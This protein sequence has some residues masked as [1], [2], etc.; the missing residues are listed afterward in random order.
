MYFKT[1]RRRAKI[2]AAL[3][4]SSF[5]LLGLVQPF[6]GT[7][8]ASLTFTKLASFPALGSASIASV[9]QSRDGS[10]I[11]VG[12]TDGYIQISRDSGATWKEQSTTACTTDCSGAPSAIG[13][14]SALAISPDGAHLIAG[15]KT[16]TTGDLWTATISET[17][18][19]WVDHPSAGHEEWKSVVISD[20]GTRMAATGFKTPN[21]HNGVIT[22]SGDSGTVWG[23]RSNPVMISKIIASPDLKIITGI[24]IG[25]Y[26]SLAGQVS[27][28]YGTTWQ[29][30]V[31]YIYYNLR[32]GAGSAAADRLVSFDKDGVFYSSTSSGLFWDDV[33]AISNAATTWTDTSISGDG[34]HIV[35]LDSAK[36]IYLSKDASATWDTTALTGSAGTATSVSIS[37]N[38]SSILALTNSE[39]WR[40]VLN[41]APNLQLDTS[42]QVGVVDH[43]ISPILPLN[44]GGAANY[45]VAPALPAGLTIDPY[46]GTVTGIPSASHAHDTY[47]LTATG[48]ADPSQHSSKTFNLSVITDYVPLSQ[49]VHLYGVIRTNGGT[50]LGNATIQYVPSQM[51]DPITTYSDASGNYD[52]LVTPGPGTIRF[53]SYSPNSVPGVTWGVAATAY[54][55]SS[56]VSDQAI[57][58]YL[59][60]SGQITIPAGMSGLHQDLTIPSFHNLHIHA[61]KHGTPNVPIP[62]ATLGLVGAHD[63]NVSIV[64]GASDCRWN[65]PFVNFSGHLFETDANGDVFVPVLDDST[66][67]KDPSQPILIAQKI[68]TV[69]TGWATFNTTGS[70]ETITATADDKPFRESTDTGAFTTVHLHGTGTVG[71]KIAWCPTLNGTDSSVL[72]FQSNCNLVDATNIAT[73]DGSGNYTLNVTEGSV[74]LKMSTGENSITTSGCIDIPHGTTD[75]VLNLISP[76]LTMKNVTIAVKDEAN[77][78]LTNVSIDGARALTSVKKRS[79]TNYD[80]QL[81]S[82]MI[83]TPTTVACSN[84]IASADSPTFNSCLWNPYAAYDSSSKTS[85]R[86]PVLTSTSALQD[87][88]LGA[89][90]NKYHFII[91]SN[92]SPADLASDGS[93]NVYGFLGRQTDLAIDPTNV[94][95]SYNVTL[96]GLKS[97][98]GIVKD[99]AGLAIANLTVYFTPDGA[100]FYDPSYTSYL[101]N[102]GHRVSAVTDNAGKFTI[103][104]MAHVPGI[105]EIY[106]NMQSP[107]SLIPSSFGHVN[108]RPTPNLPPSLQIIAHVDMTNSTSGSPFLVELPISHKLKI[109]AQS[110]TL[111]LPEIGA[112]VS[113]PFQQMSCQ[114]TISATFESCSIAP[115]NTEWQRT[116]SHGDLT[117]TVL[118][119]TKMVD[120]YLFTVFDRY[121]RVRIAT[122]II[123]TITEDTSLTVNLPDAPLKPAAIAIIP[124]ADVATLPAVVDPEPTPSPVVTPTPSDTAAPIDVATEVAVIDATSPSDFPTTIT[125]AES[126]PAN[127]EIVAIDWQPPTSDGGATITDYAVTI[128]DVTPDP[129]LFLRTTK[130]KVR[131][132]KPFTVKIPLSKFKV[133][134]S[135]PLKFMVRNQGAFLKTANSQ[136]HPHLV[137]EIKFVKDHIYRVSVAAENI[138]GLGATNKVKV[139]LKTVVSPSATPTASASH[140]STPSATSSAAPTTS[141]TNTARV[142]PTSSPISTPQ[143]VPPT[144]QVTPRPVTSQ[145]TPAVLPSQ[146]PMTVEPKKEITSPKT[147]GGGV[148]QLPP[149]K[150]KNVIKPTVSVLSSSLAAAVSVAGTVGQPIA[151]KIN[152]LPK[153]SEI[154]VS[155]ILNGKKVSLG[156]MKTNSNGSVTLPTILANKPGTYSVQMKSVN[157]KT[158][159]IKIRVKS[160]N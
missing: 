71:A 107:T 132:R 9:V 159:F 109:H 42:D 93:A 144:P 28:D 155:I 131:V 36:N 96:P 15:D 156:T 140:S 136:K 70:E 63:C 56:H 40:A 98:F 50:P 112:S 77:S 129:S 157:G 120:P 127:E 39:I 7:A 3:F 49:N 84:L 99:T 43:A 158:Y 19:T 72:G 58:R 24:T 33:P 105:L 89:G 8:S 47:T 65:D 59:E 17:G 125:P 106:T 121:D 46:L 102:S 124:I 74:C 100:F 2:T 21:E 150:A 34:S 73:V 76:G 13:K 1:S 92:D 141:A 27:D 57:P 64:P 51:V 115:V 6:Q 45:S 5:L 44:F 145:S 81:P 103:T 119:S 85:I 148:Q 108:T 22:F 154:T 118:D 146:V 31:P 128:E 139:D 11:V 79:A 152:S 25:S 30:A 110:F 149:S 68:G 48:I 117:T 142:I 97:L 114:K 135:A 104:N 116:D 32:G 95:D 54:G 75:K 41:E 88:F 143:P 123:S 61:E 151:P 52:M 82:E 12:L 87:R 137:A 101:P 38:G 37:Q 29:D 134:Y 67:A 133:L 130:G 147:L 138:V 69:A 53:V 111:G 62:N 4:I 113:T 80:S 18:T 86:V 14:W 90:D 91:S 35:A 126:V 153:S 60:L 94:L 26:Q 83:L 66:F 78:P 10:T 55:T 23:W 20:D 160:K 122:N 16:P